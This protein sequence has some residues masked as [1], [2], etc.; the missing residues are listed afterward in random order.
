[1]SDPRDLTR[2][3]FTTTHEWA[4][5][6]APGLATVGISKFAVETLTDIVHIELPAVG[7]KVN[8]GEAFGEVESVK[9]V[10]DLYSP[11]TGEVVEVNSDLPDH[12]EMLTDDCYGNGWIVKL[13]MN[14]PSEFDKLMKIE[15][16]Q[17]QCA[18]ESH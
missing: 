1:M 12:L 5:E 16:Y 6:D 9:A 11:V 17:K 3:H 15:A 4:R 18:E 8:A 7:K 13:R 10:S 14:D 2:L